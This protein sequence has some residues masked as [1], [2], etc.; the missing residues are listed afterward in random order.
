MTNP[1][2]CKI[3]GQASLWGSAFCRGHTP[4]EISDQDLFVAWNVMKQGGS[5]V[6][7]ATLIGARSPDLDLALWRRIGRDKTPET[8]RPL[9][10]APQF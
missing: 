6:K 9:R 3:C 5:L 8:P 2:P 10:P 4:D 1:R 7:A